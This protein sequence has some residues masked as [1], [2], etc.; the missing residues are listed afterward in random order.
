[1][2]SASVR[3]FSIVASSVSSGVGE[4]RDLERVER[5]L[6]GD[7]AVPV[8][9]RGTVHAV[10]DGPPA[11][12]RLTRDGTTQSHH[13]RGAIALTVDGRQVRVEIPAIEIRGPAREQRG[14]WRD[15]VARATPRFAEAGRAPFDTAAL[16][17]AELAVGDQVALIGTATHLDA[18]GKPERVTAHALARGRDADRVFGGSAPSAL[19]A[20]AGWIPCVLA[21]AGAVAWVVLEHRP[22]YG[23]ALALLAAAV[24]M[25]PGGALEELDLRAG[26]RD[27]STFAMPITAIQMLAVM[28]AIAV[29]IAAHTAAPFAGDAIG[30]LLVLFGLLSRL[31]GRAAER[32]ASRLAG[33]PVWPGGPGFARLQGTVDSDE[34]ADLDGRPIVLGY[35][36][37]CS[38]PTGRASGST[39][40]T[41]LRRSFRAATTI[42]ITTEAGAVTVAPA[43]LAWSSM[44]SER[45]DETSTYTYREWVPVGA[46]VVATGWIQGTPPQLVSRGTEPAI[47]LCGDVT[48][49]RTLLRYWRGTTYALLAIGIA[50]AAVDA[51]WIHPRI[52]SA[53]SSR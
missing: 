52:T 23:G 49:P 21:V 17:I 29:P 50:L 26:D 47:L 38:Q 22:A 36:T 18:A 30:G 14:A 7:V 37:E 35:E 28:A 12:W 46:T 27:V 1:M 42:R 51:R 2:P 34:P 53:L 4:L 32:R 13:D 45:V 33:G 16:A 6:R 48:A 9:L 19:G 31:A 39:R 41:T 10:I 15:L 5:R 44:T 25:R 11:T 40:S 3:S 24:L 43:E 8:Q 20:I